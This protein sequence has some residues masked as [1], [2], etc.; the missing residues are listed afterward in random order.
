MASVARGADAKAPTCHYTSEFNTSVPWGTTVV[1]A[2]L[3]SWPTLCSIVC[4][5]QH[6]ASELTI[7]LTTTKRDLFGV[8]LSVVSCCRG[9]LPLGPWTLRRLLCCYSGHIPCL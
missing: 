5:V 4:V 1:E 6:L 7:S 3:V 9:T 8:E 2:D